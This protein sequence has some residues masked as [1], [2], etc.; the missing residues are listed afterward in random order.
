MG[1]L[2]LV[3][4]LSGWMERSEGYGHGQGGESFSFLCFVGSGF[5]WH[6]IAWYGIEWHSVA[7]HS[8]A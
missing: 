8:I 5:F 2:V 6:C 3:R 7:S 1:V 4:E